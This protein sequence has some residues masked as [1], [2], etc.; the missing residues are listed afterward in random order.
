M[1]IKKI[2]AILLTA[3]T[4]AGGVFVNPSSAYQGEKTPQKISQ[5]Y[6]L[7]KDEKISLEE[8]DEL[9]SKYGLTRETDPNVYKESDAQPMVIENVKD[10]EDIFKATSQAA[11]GIE[12]MD[13]QADISNVDGTQKANQSATFSKGLGITVGNWSSAKFNTYI[14]FDVTNKK[15][16]KVVTTNQSLT[17]YIIGLSLKKISTTWDIASNKVSAKVTG[18]GIV[19]SHILVE[20]LPIIYNREI[21]ASGTFYAK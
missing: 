1:H 19:N 7:N 3:I 5:E 20:G 16:N 6:N 2:S 10:L 15:I 13:I 11:E 4:I 9:A 14:T 12:N 8:I 18:K 17:G 21:T